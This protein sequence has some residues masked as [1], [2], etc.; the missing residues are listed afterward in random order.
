M[1]EED[2]EKGAVSGTPEVSPTA[3][4]RHIRRIPDISVCTASKGPPNSLRRRKTINLGEIQDRLPSLVE[5]GIAKEENG[6][7]VVD[8]TSMGVDKLLGSG[9]VSKPMKIIVDEA[10]ERAIEKVKSSGGEVEIN[11]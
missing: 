3:S 9:S 11:G 8:L 10:S 5:K 4:Y 6:T 1:P 2:T 7:Y